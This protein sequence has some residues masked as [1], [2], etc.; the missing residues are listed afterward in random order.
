MARKRGGKRSVDGRGD[1]P[2]GITIIAALEIIAAVY[3]FIGFA[4]LSVVG[5]VAVGG[6]VSIITGFG[7]AVLLVSGIVLL[8]SAYS[9][10][11]GKRWGWWLELIVALVLILSIALLDI[12]GFILGVI[13]AYYLT[14][15]YVK[16]WFRL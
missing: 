11:Y 7:S 4:A 8:I 10:W 9:L 15:S 16:K 6:L 12:V 2:L 14:R 3:L 1:R 5:L 13:L